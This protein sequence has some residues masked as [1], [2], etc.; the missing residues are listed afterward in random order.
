MTGDQVKMP[1]ANQSEIEFADEG[2]AIA[3][4]DIRIT[5]NGTVAHHAAEHA[6]IDWVTVKYLGRHAPPCSDTCDYEFIASLT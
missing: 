1:K 3:F 5:P 4:A 2:R 6:Y